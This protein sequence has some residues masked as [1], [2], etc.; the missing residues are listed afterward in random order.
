MSTGTVVERVQ[1]GHQN[2]ANDVVG[3]HAHVRG[4]QIGGEVRKVW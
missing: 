4:G 1:C 3:A 2:A